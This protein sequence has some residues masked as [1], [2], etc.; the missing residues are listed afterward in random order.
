V[1]LVAN[2][3]AAKYSRKL[4]SCRRRNATVSV[5]GANIREWLADFGQ[6][7][8]RKINFEELPD[9]RAVDVLPKLGPVTREV[10][11][12][13]KERS[14]ALFCTVRIRGDMDRDEG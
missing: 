8:V 9:C 7:D 11:T 4:S 6:F 1:P 10:Q 3:Q 13:I 5:N 12:F 2:N 14:K